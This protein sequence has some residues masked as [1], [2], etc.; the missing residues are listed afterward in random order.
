MKQQQL[1][2]MNLQM[3]AHPADPAPQDPAPQDPPAEPAKPNESTPPTDPASDKKYSDADVDGIINA[4]FAKW[5]ADQEEKDRVAKLSVAEKEQERIAKLEKLEHDVA[6]RDAVDKSRK[7]LNDEKLPDSFAKFIAD[8]KEDVSQEK[9]NE[10]KGMMQAFR[11]SIV[12]EVM[13]DK[14]PTKPKV[15]DD[16]KADGWRN[17]IQQAYEKTKGE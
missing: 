7:M 13:K 12:A 5:Q 2:P 11:E 3:F 16:G 15:V 6:Q 9:F 17:K 14:T 1:L 10:F 8:T 4:R